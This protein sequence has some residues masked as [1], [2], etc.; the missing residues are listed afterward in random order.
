MRM[1][2]L[3]RVAFSLVVEG[4]VEP[5][6]RAITERVTISDDRHRRVACLRRPGAGDRRSGRDVRRLTPKFVKRYAEIGDQMTAAAIAYAADVRARRF[7][8]KEHLFGAE[9]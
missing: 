4:V 8:G 2:S 5:L 3:R 6:A 9:N 1:R 7:P